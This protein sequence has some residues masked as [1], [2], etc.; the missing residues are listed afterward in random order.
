MQWRSQLVVGAPANLRHLEKIFEPN[1]STCS[2]NLKQWFESG[3]FDA[4]AT[5]KSD[6]QQV[7]D[8]AAEGGVS[9]LACV[10]I[11][12]GTLDE[13]KA[14]TDILSKA[15]DASK[16]AGIQ[17]TFHNHWIEFNE[18][19]GYLPYNY[20]LNKTDKDLVKM[21][22]DLAW[23]TRAKQDSIEL[24]KK[25]P[26]RFLLCHI[27]SLRKQQSN[28]LKLEPVTLTSNAFL[29]KQSKQG[30]NIIL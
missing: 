30:C 16:K 13:L 17:L 27:K 24:F 29:T 2:L 28:L 18:A 4:Y 20:I 1:A 11:R 5:L 19:E 23:A 22:F 10:T 6:Y 12:I 9:Y 14:A 26:G 25:Y 7:I 3:S 8:E 21:E 15:G